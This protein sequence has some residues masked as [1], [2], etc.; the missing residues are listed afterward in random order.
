MK[1]LPSKLFP[2]CS[3]PSDKGVGF[4]DITPEGFNHVISLYL[5]SETV[6]DDEAIA[7]AADFFDKA[8]EWDSFC[9]DAFLSV[10]EDSDD[11]KMILEY[12]SFYKDEVPEV[13]GVPDASVLSLSDMVRCLILSHMGTHGIG[14]EQ[15][16]NVDF[17]L[18]Y[19]QLLCVYFDCDGT[20]DHIA[21][22]S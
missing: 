4:Y 16:Y 21:W 6:K 7:K 10:P 9:R 1:T 13:F 18:G 2:N 12:F 3:F 19:D 22:E 11:Y 17:T 20:F 5:G 15:K 8:S 14:S